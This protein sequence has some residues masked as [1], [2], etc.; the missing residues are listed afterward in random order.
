MNDRYESWKKKRPNVRG[1][2]NA[3]QP[4]NGKKES[5]K[6]KSN[7]ERNRRNKNNKKRKPNSEPESIKGTLALKRV[8]SYPSHEMT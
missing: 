3:E 7:N 6:K 4:G 1:N 5:V 2:S 8:R